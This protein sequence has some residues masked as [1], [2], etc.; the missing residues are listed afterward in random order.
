MYI[1]KWEF[2]GGGGG[3]G[4][5]LK[6][7]VKIPLKFKEN[8]EL[9]GGG[10]QTAPPLATGLRILLCAQFLTRSTCTPVYVILACRVRRTLINR[11]R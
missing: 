11:M 2:R 10:G 7:S 1:S 9:G 4:Q 8:L 3:G 6:K 5:S